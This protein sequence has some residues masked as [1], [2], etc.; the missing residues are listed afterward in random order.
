MKQVFDQRRLEYENQLQAAQRSIGEYERKLIALQAELESLGF[1]NRAKTDEVNQWR[2]KAVLIENIKNQEIERLRQEFEIEKRELGERIIND[3][4]EAERSQ[5]NTKI[6]E[7]KAKINDLE[8]KNTH[9]TVELERQSSLYKTKAKE[10]ENWREKYNRLESSK[11]VEIDEV[12]N[13]VELL[14]HS[15]LVRFYY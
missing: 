10:V 15:S 2:E 5:A 1:Q 4:V 8:S 13:Q 6:R 9:I 14:K 3:R 11:F 12:K 7:L